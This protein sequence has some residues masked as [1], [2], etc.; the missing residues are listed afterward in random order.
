[1]TSDGSKQGESP[2]GGSKGPDSKAIADGEG[3]LADATVTQLLALG[4]TRQ[5]RPV[6][7]LIERL[8][9]PDGAGWFDLQTR[10]PIMSSC[11]DPAAGLVRGAWG[12][13]QVDRFKDACKLKALT[14]PDTSARLTAL[15]AYF[16]AIA[17]AIV[18]H[19][20][21]ITSQSPR[22]LE[23]VLAELAG[24]TPEP[25]SGLFAQAVVELNAAG[26]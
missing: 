5:Q 7:R 4:V 10:T 18:H 15:A 24:A 17:S 6:E 22:E 23:E 19:R 25:W 11:G 9:A 1:M 8:V 13:V 16:I 3:V 20:R 21:L 26:R 14:D 12:L 2:G